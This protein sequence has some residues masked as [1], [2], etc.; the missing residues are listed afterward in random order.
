MH[1]DDSSGAHSRASTVACAIAGTC[2]NSEFAAFAYRPGGLG[3]DTFIRIG[4]L[5][6]AR[7]TGPMISFRLPISTVFP[8]SVPAMASRSA[9]SSRRAFGCTCLLVWAAGLATLGPPP[10]SYSARAKPAPKATTIK[11]ARKEISR[12][13]RTPLEVAWFTGHEANPPMPACQRTRPM[14]PLTDDCNP[15]FLSPRTA[16]VARPPT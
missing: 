13:A 14:L 10:E 1:G 11:V 3:A 9:A 16:S 4:F 6:G 7:R 12:M 5:A 8:T 15:P 2:T